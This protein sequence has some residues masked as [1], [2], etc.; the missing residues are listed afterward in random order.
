MGGVLLSPML[1]VGI[2]RT[3]W[4]IEKKYVTGRNEKKKLEGEK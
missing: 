3:H 2:Y 4:A 1:N